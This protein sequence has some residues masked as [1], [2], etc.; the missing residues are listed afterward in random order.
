M[1]ETDDTTSNTTTKNINKELQDFSQYTYDMLQIVKT[2][3]DHPGEYKELYQVYF[4]I[5]NYLDSMMSSIEGLKF[6]DEEYALPFNFIFLPYRE[7][8][9]RKVLYKAETNLRDLLG[10]IE[11]KRRLLLGEAYK[12]NTGINNLELREMLENIKSGKTIKIENQVFDDDDDDDH[13]VSDI[14]Q[15]IEVSN[16]VKKSYKDIEFVH[17]RGKGYIRFK[18]GKRLYKLGGYNT[19]TYK[20][21]KYIL[22][23]TGKTKKVIDVFEYIK[24]P[25]DRNNHD[26]EENDPRSYQLK[27]EVIDNAVA[28]LQKDRFIK[29][30]VSNPVFNEREKTVTI[31]FK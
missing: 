2:V 29:G 12:P 15:K 20:M 3:I 17:L 7:E 28:E 25:R 18:K 4:D 16:V 10:R 31:T 27:K 21:A 6:M 23:F 19:R 13:D 8:S 30:H 24:I 9:D 26:L 5:S 22:E 11:A 14:E 1:P